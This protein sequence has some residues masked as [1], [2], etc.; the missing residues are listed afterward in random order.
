MTLSHKDA[1]S[2]VEVA[3]LRRFGRAPTRPEAQC[4]QA[5]GWL[6][7]NYGG[8]WKPGEGLGSNNWGAITAGG[9]W[10]G[11]T[12]EHRDSRPR[13]DG[14]NEWYVTK[15]RAYKTPA[16]GAEDLVRVVYQLVI[17]RGPSLDR[18]VMVLRPATQGDVL[19][20][21]TGLYDS[22]YYAGFGKNRDERIAGHYAKMIRSLRQIAKAIGEAMPDGTEP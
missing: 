1:R 4:V 21:S 19:G 16:D 10:T 12:F 2:V 14:T 15:F 8:G 6:E 3:F 22:K 17:G 20:V 5:V 13:P 9:S 18:S 11:A 7:T